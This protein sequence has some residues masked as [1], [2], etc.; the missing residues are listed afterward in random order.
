HARWERAGWPPTMQAWCPGLVTNKNGRGASAKSVT[1]PSVVT[2]SHKMV[3]IDETLI[4]SVVEQVLSR[5]GGLIP[6]SPN[7]SYQGRFGLFSDVP[8]AVAAASEA[9]ERLGRA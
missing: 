5:M 6:P 4:R 7:G 9:F 1:T 3:Q 2:R 8:S